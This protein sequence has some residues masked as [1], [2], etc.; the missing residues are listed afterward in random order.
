MGISGALLPNTVDFTH[1]T[2]DVNGFQVLPS[3]LQQSNQKVN[4]QLNVD[5]QL[6]LGQIDISDGDT[7]AKNLFQLELDLRLHVSDLGSHI[8]GMEDK[9]RELSGLVQTRTEQTGNLLNDRFRSEEGVVFLG[10][11][12]DD[13]LVLV[14]GLEGIDV[15]VINTDLF[16]FITVLLITENTD[17]EGWL[18]GV[19]ELNTSTET[20]ILLRIVV[21]ETDL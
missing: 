16:G 13:L 6:I 11:L 14:D 20:F 18:G 10:H 17:L 7:H 12:L 4:S 8:I 3:L 21:L 1:G 19:W 5:H 15:H 2:L 9:G